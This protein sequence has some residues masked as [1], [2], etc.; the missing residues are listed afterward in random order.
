MSDIALTWDDFS[1]DFSISANDLT[2]D[3][4]LQTAV[5][6]SLFTD[7]PSGDDQISD[8]DDRGFWGDAV[9]V[10][11]GDVFGSRLWLLA[12]AKETTETLKL[13]EGYAK[14]ALAWLIEDRVASKVDISASW[15]SS[16]ILGISVQIQRPSRDVISFQFSKTWA[17]QEVA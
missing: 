14:E 8:L 5:S 2:S 10:V 3:H 6:L 1:A 4:G 9:P 7:A 11:A 13:A 12:R 17:A 16:G 15:V